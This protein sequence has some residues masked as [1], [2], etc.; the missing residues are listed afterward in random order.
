MDPRWA[1][2]RVCLGCVAHFKSHIWATHLFQFAISESIWLLFRCA[3]QRPVSIR[4]GSTSTLPRCSWASGRISRECW[5]STTWGCP[6]SSSGGSDRPFRILRSGRVRCHL[7]LLEDHD[8]PPS[9]C[10][11]ELC[12]FRRHHLW[13]FFNA[14]FLQLTP[15]DACY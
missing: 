8:I 15:W 2:K 10:Q 6:W 9:S 3:S 12:T 4:E 1:C 7:Q 13:S 5:S 11:V 14:K